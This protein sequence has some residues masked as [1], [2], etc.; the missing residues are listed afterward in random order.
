M[1]DLW[2]PGMLRQALNL[3][4]L[5]MSAVPMPQARLLQKRPVAESTRFRASQVGSEA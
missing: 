2:V 5:T 4:Y 1:P 3:M